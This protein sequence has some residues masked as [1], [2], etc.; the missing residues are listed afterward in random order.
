MRYKGDDAL[1]EA[2]R[3]QPAAMELLTE[4]Q[5]ALGSGTGLVLADTHASTYLQNPLKQID[6]SGLA[7][8]DHLWS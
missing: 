8:D 5:Q 7:S 4:M 6:C 3:M 2:K 1:R